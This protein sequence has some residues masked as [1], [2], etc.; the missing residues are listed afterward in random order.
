MTTKEIIELLKKKETDFLKTNSFSKFP[1]IYA[2]FY[3]GNDFPLL[4]ET[5][6]KHQIIYIG[7]TETSQEKRDAKT[8]FTSGKT[9]SS[10]VRK[11]IG[12]ILCAQE[13][14]KPIPRNDSDYAKGRFSHFKFDNPSEIK[15][16][17]WME[18]NLAL[19]FYEYPKTKQEIE[20]LETE[21]I[22]E[23]VPILNISKNPKNAFRDTLQQL[24]K[25][26]ATIAAKD[27]KPNEIRTQSNSINHQRTKSIISSSGKYIDLWTR[28][29]ASIK[30]KLKN[31]M[32]K[33][34]IQLNS[35]E[36][37]NV[38]KRSNYSFNLE[39][40]NGIVSNNI[41]GSAVARDLANVLETS[42]EINEILK[43]GNFK[44]NMDRR[45]CLWIQRK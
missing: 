26:C 13:N 21:I 39:F 16:T 9:G 40:E 41:G 32:I 19:S 5:V 29:R 36:F 28:Q 15:I 34:S 35:E 10:T 24:R 2:F 11:S 7:K 22:N 20:D 45:F 37:R 44:I 14:L 30:D 27:F 42:T 33:Q 8:H 12:S 6:S 23:L 38:G 18:N 25:N 31:T 1:G 4:G 17:D 3:I 43:T